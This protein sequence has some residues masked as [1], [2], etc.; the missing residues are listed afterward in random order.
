MT[1]HIE[2]YYDFISPYAYLAH[3]R[4]INIEKSEKIKFLYKP[5]LLGGLHN[6]RKITPAAFI[7][8]KKKFTVNDCQLI[9]NKFKI[10]FKFNENF[11]MNSLS[12][13]RGV[14]VVDDK[15]SKKYIEKF[16]DA[17]W[18]LN[19]DLSNK[20]VMEKILKKLNIN[21]EKFFEKINEQKTKDSLKKILK[22]LSIKKFLVHQLLL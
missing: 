14:L 17:Y 6:L 5:I 2:F 15:K 22:M 18:G 4:I 12:L 16:F 19:L 13:M 10:K 1:N 11:P 20:Q 3:K 7:E 9:A 21:C 8:A